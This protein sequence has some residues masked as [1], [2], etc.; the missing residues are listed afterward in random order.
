M[1]C[2]ELLA[3]AKPPHF[4]TGS[5]GGLIKVLTV[6]LVGYGSQQ[7]CAVWWWWGRLCEPVV[8]YMLPTE[9]QML[10][11]KLENLMFARFSLMSSC[12]GK[13]LLSMCCYAGS[14]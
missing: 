10:S 8:A 6:L 7:C 13:G 12:F 1:V 14:M 3:P 11:T 4:R 2:L 5:A 9:H